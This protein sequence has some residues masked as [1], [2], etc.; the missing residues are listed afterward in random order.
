MPKKS[1]VTDNFKEI[2]ML[3]NVKIILIVIM[4]IS[5]ATI[6]GN[7]KE[8]NL[9][10]ACENYFKNFK[11]IL[12]E[13][14]DV[15]KINNTVSTKDN[16]R[17]KLEIAC[18]N[19]LKNFK[20]ILPE[21]KDILKK[22][23]KAPPKKETPKQKPIVKPKPVKKPNIIIP[24]MI[25]LASNKF[26]MG[27]ED[28]DAYENEKPI[29][30]VSL[31]Y[32]FYIAETEVTQKEWKVL[33]GNNP[34]YFKDD[35]LPVETVSWFD[36]IKYCNKL[37]KS[38]N[39]P[40]P[41]DESTGDLLDSSGN[42]T[43]DIILVKGYRL[44]TEAEWEYAAKG[45]KY[46]KSYKYSGNNDPNEIAWYDNNS[47]SRTNQV[48]TKKPNELGIYD[49]SGNVGEWC[50]DW[51]KN[52]SSD[53][54]TTYV[55]EKASRHVVRGGNWNS[56]ELNIRSSNRY[57]SIPSFSSYRLGFRLVKIE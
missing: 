22:N 25:F 39:L 31:E 55:F 13:C 53:N 26:N 43:T 57:Y 34:S 3:K 9:K 12:P 7:T 37:S 10:K 21:C 36:A 41:Y 15:L 19:H 52:Y 33:M 30:K 6:E 5:I 2:I 38:Q 45:G 4:S 24:N 49:M 8:S 44:P 50:T 48:G 54:E 14:K 20:E 18:E 17:K 28:L 35:S 51:Y 42:I 56:I 47:D 27:S 1:M 46:S 23:S 40:L 11:E 32:N 29:H 16:P